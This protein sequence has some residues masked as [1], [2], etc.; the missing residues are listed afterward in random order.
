MACNWLYH[1]RLIAP[2]GLKMVSYDFW[3]SPSWHRS[4]SKDQIQPT[5]RKRQPNDS[6]ASLQHHQWLKYPVRISI[7]FQ[8]ALPTFQSTRSWRSIIVVNCITFCSSYEST[9][10]LWLNW[11]HDRSPVITDLV[12]VRLLKHHFSLS[13]WYLSSHWNQACYSFEFSM[14]TL[15][16]IDL[17][18][19]FSSNSD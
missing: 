10:N 18:F 15:M 5:S 12:R 17:D 11:F 16:F 4:G 3:P 7:L 1:E 13:L 19:A 6:S 8:L 2:V 14:K 9:A